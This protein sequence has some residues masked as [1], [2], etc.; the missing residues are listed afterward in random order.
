MN[1]DYLFREV[2]KMNSLLSF[3]ERFQIIHGNV[4]VEIVYLVQWTVCL[5]RVFRIRRLSSIPP[6]SNVSMTMGSLNHKFFFPWAVISGA[7]TM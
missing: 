7:L 4:D 3:E 1:Q 2:Q 5:R 6:A